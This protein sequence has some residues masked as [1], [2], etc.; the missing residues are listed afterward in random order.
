[1]SNMQIFQYG[2]N[3]VRTVVQD[4]EPWF[5]LKDVCEVLGL[6]TTQLKKVA[7]R[8]ESDEK[9]RNLIPTPGGAQESWII[10]ESGL[11]NV[12]LRSAL[13]RMRSVRPRSSTAWGVSNTPHLQGCQSD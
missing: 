1:M 12:I 8:L 10:N 5:V 6:D 3:P 4:G 9:G 2:E 11:Y 7:D 13:N